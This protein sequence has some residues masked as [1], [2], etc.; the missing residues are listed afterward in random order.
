MGNNVHDLDFAVPVDVFTQAR[1]VADG[2]SA[3][4]YP[5]D[6]EHGTARVIVEQPAGDK[7]FLDFS[8]IRGG[9]IQGD[10]GERDFTLNAMAIDIYHKGV[11]IDPLNGA[12]DLKDKLL[13]VCSQD[14]INSD[15]I[16]VRAWNPP[17]SSI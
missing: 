7:L 2:L 17:G 15:P 16:R 11:V 12:Q 5:M 4:Y 13:Q 1:K 10:L 8:Q 9:S 3:A 6:D 14:S